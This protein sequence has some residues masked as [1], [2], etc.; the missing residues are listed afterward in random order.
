MGNVSS[1]EDR[2]DRLNDDMA[3]PVSEFTATGTL[4]AGHLQSLRERTETVLTRAIT[5]VAELSELV[6]L[7]TDPTVNVA[8]QL[9][10]TTASIGALEARAAKAEKAAHD[11]AFEN[12]QLAKRIASL[13]QK[14][15][16]AQSELRRRGLGPSRRTR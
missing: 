9:R 12:A 2:L 10:D 11:Q 15:G 4:S 16:V 3:A 14:L 7:A 5:A 8:R 6:S 13:E 1:L